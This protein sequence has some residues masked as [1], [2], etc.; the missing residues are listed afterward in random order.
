MRVKLTALLI[1]LCFLSCSEKFCQKLH[2]ANLQ[3]AQTM[4]YSW[5]CSAEKVTKSLD[6][7]SDSTLCVKHPATRG[8]EGTIAALACKMAVSL[9]AGL[10]AEQMAKKWDCSI[11]KVYATLNTAGTACAGL[12]LL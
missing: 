2:R 11:A 3:V 10:T 1:A 6:K 7:L 8:V 12:A 5:G 9:V 4:S